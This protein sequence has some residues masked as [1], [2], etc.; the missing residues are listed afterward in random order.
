MLC[1][2]LHPLIV[3]PTGNSVL[4]PI[5]AQQ[6]N[7]S[8]AL[9]SAIDSISVNWSADTRLNLILV[10]NQEPKMEQLNRSHGFSSDP[11]NRAAPANRKNKHV[12]T[13]RGMMVPIKKTE[14]EAKE[15]MHLSE[16]SRYDPKGKMRQRRQPS[17]QK[18]N[19]GDVPQV[20]GH[21]ERHTLPT[22]SSNANTSTS[23]NRRRNH[24][25]T[26]R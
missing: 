1:S 10:P 13:I 21:N 12:N 25:H 7:Y 4:A 15:G 3:P 24:N 23:R 5:V 11:N 18:G 9:L 26:R 2:C 6:R 22:R 8:Q 17:V 14:N 19:A 20:L 16:Q